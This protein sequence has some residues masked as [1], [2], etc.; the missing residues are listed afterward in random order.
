MLAFANKDV[1]TVIITKFHM[2]RSSET[3]VIKTHK[4]PDETSRG[5]N[6]L[7]GI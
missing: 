3:W 4:D 7:D 6:I 2:F 1:K 5:G